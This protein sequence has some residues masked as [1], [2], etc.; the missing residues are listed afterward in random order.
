MRGLVPLT[1]ELWNEVPPNQPLLLTGRAGS[2]G[3]ARGGQQRARQQSG[4][5][6]GRRPT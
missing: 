2:P 3:A 1:R 4:T 5:S 6:F